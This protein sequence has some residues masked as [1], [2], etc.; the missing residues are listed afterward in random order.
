MHTKVYTS[1]YKQWCHILLHAGI[2][3]VCSEC[4]E[5]SKDESLL[6]IQCYFPTV[7]SPLKLSTVAQNIQTGYLVPIR[8]RPVN[9]S[10]KPFELCNLRKCK[11]EKSCIY[12]H[13]EI[14]C[15]AWNFDLKNIKGIL[16][17]HNY[18]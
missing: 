5:S 10:K 11:G 4:L 9:D 6:S 1:L 8:P 13:S 15:N 7:H 3:E 2:L 16:Y 18:F 14:E 12:A 17:L